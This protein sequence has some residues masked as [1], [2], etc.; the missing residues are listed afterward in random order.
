LISAMRTWLS[1]MR[2]SASRLLIWFSINRNS[3]K[4]A[5]EL[6]LTFDKSARVLEIRFSNFCCSFLSFSWLVCPKTAPKK[7]KKNSKLLTFFILL[8]NNNN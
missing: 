4:D 8:W 3:F 7:Q 6:D 5:W 1:K 2:T